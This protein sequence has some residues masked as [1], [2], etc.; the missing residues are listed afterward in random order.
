MNNEIAQA[1]LVTFAALATLIFIAVGFVFLM[2][3]LKVRRAFRSFDRFVMSASPVSMRF[4]NLV[5]PRYMQDP[6]KEFTDGR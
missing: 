5:K 4:N 1:M 2:A 3:Y 6:F